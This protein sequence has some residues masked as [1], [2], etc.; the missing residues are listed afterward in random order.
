[1]SSYSTPT[2][3]TNVTPLR[4][5]PPK[6]T[7]PPEADRENPFIQALNPVEQDLIQ[8]EK[9][10]IHSLESNV[11]GVPEMMAYLIESGG[12]RIRPMFSC[13]LARAWGYTGDHHIPVACVAELLHTATLY[14]DDVVDH[15]EIRRGKPTANSIFGNKIIVL[16]G[17][18]MLAHCFSMLMEGGY[19]LISR[20][21]SRTVKK[22]VEGE[23]L[24]LQCEGNLDTT[25][26][27]YLKVIEHKTASLFS[28]CSQAA[29][30]LANASPE[31]C[32]EMGRFGHHLGM[33]FQLVDDLMDFTGDHQKM[34]KTPLN[35]LK[36]G[37]IT[38]PLLLTLKRHPEFKEELEEALIKTDSSLQS[39]SYL[40]LQKFVREP[41]IVQE[42]RDLIQ[43]HL[44]QAQNLLPLL[45]ESKYRHSLGS[46]IQYLEQRDR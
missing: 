3:A 5:K 16:A 15:A 27:Q 38:L 32:R 42:N 21:L 8:V 11:A 10:L 26:E 25:T 29:A 45:P 9:R 30:M 1:M 37:K 31:V 18:L 20:A 19:F 12:K 17:D 33:A 41:E 39:P 6:K 35:D 22:M 13:L 28:W 23:I 14:H 44:R 24:Q 2:A 46:L 43:N 4:A 40:Q 7:S 36:E 34:G